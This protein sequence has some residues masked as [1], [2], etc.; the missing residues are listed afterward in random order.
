MGIVLSRS[1]D[2]LTVLSNG[3]LRQRVVEPIFCM[4]LLRLVL[5]DPRIR[6]GMCDNEG[7]GARNAEPQTFILAG[8]VST[9]NFRSFRHCCSFGQM[10]HFIIIGKK[11]KQKR[12]P[13]PRSHPNCTAAT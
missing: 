4:F 10:T 13:Q 6:R 9:C 3:M 1:Q 2:P 5:D 11:K 7:H 12:R 8:Q